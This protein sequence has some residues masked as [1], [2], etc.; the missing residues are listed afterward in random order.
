MNTRDYLEKTIVLARQALDSGNYPIGSL[1]IDESGTVVAEGQNENFSTRDISAHAE[2]QCLRKMDINTL[3]DPHRKFMLISSAEPCCACSFFIARTNISDVHFA[4]IDPQKAGM[5]DL[6]HTPEF[7]GFF[8]AMT[9]TEAPY[10]DLKEQSA[11]LWKQYYVKIGKPE[12]AKL[13]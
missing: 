8:G 11:S 6:K 1:I 4:M 9:V 7:D 10:A 3:L 12:K 2:I 5:A 13:Y